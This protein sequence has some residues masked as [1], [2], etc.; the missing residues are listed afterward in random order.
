MIDVRVI[1]SSGKVGLHVV[2]DDAEN[3]V[4]KN[5]A[6]EPW[7]WMGRILWLDARVAAAV[8]PQMQ[9]V[10]LTMEEDA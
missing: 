5:L 10:G 3:W 2:T 9:V 6:S 1:R 7:Q 4:A 8:I